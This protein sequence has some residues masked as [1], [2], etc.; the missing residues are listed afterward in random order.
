MILSRWESPPLLA[1]V[2]PATAAANVVVSVVVSPLPVVDRDVFRV[3]LFPGGM[4]DVVTVVT[5]EPEV[6]V[7]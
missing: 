7:D 6:D 2:E 4:L 1:S 5:V 3:V